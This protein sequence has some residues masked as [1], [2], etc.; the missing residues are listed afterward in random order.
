MYLL[1]IGRHALDV[2]VTFI[3]LM[4]FDMSG[5][6][7]EGGVSRALLQNFFIFLTETAGINKYFVHILFPRNKGASGTFC[8]SE[9]LWR[10]SMVE[11]G[12]G[13]LWIPSLR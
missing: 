9:I 8:T 11:R 7:H 1:T 4:V 6:H 13:L 12:R 3:E 2:T 10:V 5:K